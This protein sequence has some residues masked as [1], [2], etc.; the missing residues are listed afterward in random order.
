M[1]KLNKEK[2]QRQ[3]QRERKVFELLQKDGPRLK[4]LARARGYPFRFFDFLD[5]N[6]GVFKDLAGEALRTHPSLVSITELSFQ[7]YQNQ[8]IRKYGIEPDWKHIV[9]HDENLTDET[10]NDQGADANL[11]GFTKTFEEPDGTL[12][13]VVHIAES[14]R[15]R[16]QHRDLKYHFKLIA[17]LHELGHVKDIESQINFSIS[18]R[19]VNTLSAEVHAHNYALKEAN[20]L[21]LLMI[22]ESLIDS[23]K[24]HVEGDGY[25]AE[26]ARRV[27]CDYQSPKATDWRELTSGDVTTAEL[28]LMKT[29]S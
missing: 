18:T 1:A 8:D 5:S 3:W 6:E 24:N 12:R 4:T 21:G 22:A 11:N 7:D 26:V 14:V 29:V 17:L 28:A 25:R 19:T 23:L 2:K 27:I 20:R 10:H 15:C 16:F 13:T 9:F